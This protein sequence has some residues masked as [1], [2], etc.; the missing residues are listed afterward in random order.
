MNLSRVAKLSICICPIL[1]LS[2]FIVGALRSSDAEEIYNEAIEYVKGERYDSALMQFRSVIREF[3]E[4]VYARESAFAIGEYFYMKKIYN[5]AVKNFSEYIENYPESK[6]TIVARAMVLKIMRHS[7]NPSITVKKM[8]NNL[9]RS[10][11]EK[12]LMILFSDHKELEYISPMQN[13][14]IIRHYL[15]RIEVYRNDKLFFEINQ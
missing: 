14:F 5:Q 9:I 11:F 7:K 2:V 1:L 3:P 13:K 4:S 15:D 10:F 8:I 12:P 6:A